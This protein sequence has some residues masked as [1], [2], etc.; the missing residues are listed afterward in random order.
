MARCKRSALSDAF[1]RPS[2]NMDPRC[3]TLSVSIVS[4]VIESTVED[5]PNENSTIKNS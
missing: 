1:P 4:D 2:D 3:T 5:K